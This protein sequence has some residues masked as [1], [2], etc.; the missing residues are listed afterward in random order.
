M[1]AS[2]PAAAELAAVLGG[3]GASVEVLD[4]PVGAAATRK[5]LRSVFCKGMAAAVVEAMEAAKA[6]G[7]EE[8]PRGNIRDELIRGNAATLDRLIDGS[9]KHGLKVQGPRGHLQQR[10]H[11]RRRV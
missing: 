7:L 8:W 11:R 4:G 9:L 5:L 1:T 3:F 6:A 2:G 10:L